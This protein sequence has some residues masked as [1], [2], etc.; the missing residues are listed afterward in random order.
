M[1]KTFSKF[2]TWIL[3]GIVLLFLLLVSVQLHIQIPLT[4]Y[5]V[6]LQVLQMNPDGI[7]AAH[8]TDTV[9]VHILIHPI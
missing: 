9:T 2:S 4:G 1:R 6:S 8:L 7:T 3:N 5:R